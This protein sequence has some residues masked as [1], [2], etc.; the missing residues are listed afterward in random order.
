MLWGKT[1]VVSGSG[2]SPPCFLAMKRLFLDQN[3]N[4]FERSYLRLSPSFIHLS[5]DD[6][7]I[8]CHQVPFVS[9]FSPLVVVPHVV[10]TST[11]M[12]TDMHIIFCAASWIPDFSI[13][14]TP[15]FAITIL[16]FS[17]SLDSVSYHTYTGV[18]NMIHKITAIYFL[19]KP[20]GGKRV[21][22]EMKH[23]ISATR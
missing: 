17:C 2:C 18:S 23:E 20:S 12:H 1:T 19:S 22:R 9:E 6:R 21:L 13:L 4:R 11:S 15:H 16:H 10:G 7:L 5:Y 14:L 3:W 8:F